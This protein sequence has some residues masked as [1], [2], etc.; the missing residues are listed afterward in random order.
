MLR[1]GYDGGR[2]GFIFLPSEISRSQN[3]H[4]DLNRTYKDALTAGFTFRALCLARIAFLFLDLNEALVASKLQL[5]GQS[6]PALALLQ[7]TSGDVHGQRTV[8]HKLG[9]LARRGALLPFQRRIASSNTCA[10][11]MRQC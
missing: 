7:V 8:G 11:E 4:E 2:S 3:L 1:E 10:A 9:N 6:L 5:C